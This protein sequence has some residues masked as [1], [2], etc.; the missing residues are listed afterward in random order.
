MVSIW[1]EYHFSLFLFW[2]VCVF[3]LYW[4]SSRKH[5]V[6]FYFSNSFFQYLP[7]IGEFK[8]FTLKVIYDEEGLKSSSF[9][10]VSVCFI[11]FYPSFPPLLPF[12]GLVD[13]YSESF[14][15]PF[16]LFLC[17]FFKCLS[18]SWR[19]LFFFPFSFY[20]QPVVYVSSQARGSCTCGLCHSHSNTEP[21]PHL[22]PML[23]LIA[24]PYP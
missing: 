5:I 13:L 16:H 20:G 23:Q 21:K 7:L 8:S 19:W 15:C 6:I 18:L 10:F 3:D 2:T 17:I 24:T 22:W 4:V 9:L 1:V 14:W 11:H 12:L